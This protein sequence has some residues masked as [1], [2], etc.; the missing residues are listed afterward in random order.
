MTNDCRLASI[1]S[2]KFSKKFEY[3]LEIDTSLIDWLREIFKTNN[4][5]RERE[6]HYVK[7]IQT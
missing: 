5:E 4:L 3:E 1:K 6:L 2:L 7:A